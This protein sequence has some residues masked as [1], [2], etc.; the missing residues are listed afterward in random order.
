MLRWL[1][2]A[3]TFPLRV[4]F[5]VAPG[6]CRACSARRNGHMYDEEEGTIW[7][8]KRLWQSCYKC[9]NRAQIVSR[10]T[11][12]PLRP[13]PTSHPGAT[14][15]PSGAHGP[16]VAVRRSDAWAARAE[17]PRRTERGGQRGGSATTAGEEPGVCCG[18]LYVRAQALIPGEQ[19]LGAWEG[20][21]LRG[22][23]ASCEHGEGAPGRRD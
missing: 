19:L 11:A 1:W 5:F 22:L 9:G 12:R 7:D 8:R 16:G 17:G 21:R 10:G 18:G 23:P 15:E 14:R 20:R 6:A 2:R 13:C 3:D 4:L